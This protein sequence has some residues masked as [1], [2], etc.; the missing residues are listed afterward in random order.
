M[1]APRTREDVSSLGA[2]VGTVGGNLVERNPKPRC[3]DLPEAW[4]AMAESPEILSQQPVIGVLHV[5]REFA[6][7]ALTDLT[8]TN[9]YLYRIEM[10]LIK[11]LSLAHVA[12]GRPLTS[13]HKS[14]LKKAVQDL[15]K[16]GAVAITGDTSALVYCKSDI[17]VYTRLPVLVTPLQQASLITSLFPKTATFLVLTAD[18]GSPAAPGSSSTDAPERVKDVLRRVGVEEASLSRFLTRSLADTEGFRPSATVASV[19]RTGEGIVNLVSGAQGENSTLACVILENTMMPAYADL[20]RT[21]CGLAVFDSVTLVDVVHTARADN[22]R[23][24]LQFGS[25]PVD[26]PTPRKT[27]EQMP[28]L[29]I[30]RIDY[31]YP[32]ALGDAAHPMSYGYNTPHATAKGLTFE[33]AMEGQPLTPGLLA[34]VRDAV[35]QLEA[36]PKVVGIAGDCG[37]LV[38]YQADVVA[39]T[40]RVPCL[41]SSMLLSHFISSIFDGTERVLVLTAHGPSLESAMRRILALCGV[42]AGNTNRF[43]VGGCEALPAFQPVLTGHKVDTKSLEPQVVDLVRRRLKADKRIVAIILECTELP[44]Y[45]DALRHAFR[46]PVFDCIVLSDYYLHAF[47]GNPYWGIDWRRLAQIPAQKRRSSLL[48]K[49]VPKKNK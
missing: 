2:E 13:K 38:Q 36:D 18:G 9:S 16:R 17:M 7:P 45:A 46:L 23:F 5:E 6:A 30:L 41:V 32:P 26:R 19:E 8:G 14:A 29:G 28:S 10:T 48:G 39:A 37:F 25:T 40:H 43:V 20:V 42:V 35:A 11:G 47:S 12:A 3:A 31:T 22:P 34:S 27:R 44:P 4:R 1:S 33:K 49:L 21:R 15:E 24:G